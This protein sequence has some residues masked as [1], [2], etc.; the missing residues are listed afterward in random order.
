MADSVNDFRFEE[1]LGTKGIS[2]PSPEE[3]SDVKSPG[4]SYTDAGLGMD[5]EQLGQQQ[6]PRKRRRWG[7][8]FM[9]LTL[10]TGL[11][12]TGVHFRDLISK[13]V[14]RLYHAAR[15]RVESIDF[16]RS[17]EARAEAQ[18]RT[19]YKLSVRTKPRGASVFVQERMGTRTV[20]RRLGRAR[21]NFSP[22]LPPGEHTI[23]LRKRGHR[24]VT[25]NVSAESSV[26][27]V[28]LPRL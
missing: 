6:T 12:V 5:L 3:V 17:A 20:E 14:Q 13:Q 7:R 25:V 8:T 21:R 27:D 2:L 26:V 19:P 1:A 28:A 16:N 10:L 11:A 15:A 4:Y 22:M 24:T 9:T 23:V 18:V